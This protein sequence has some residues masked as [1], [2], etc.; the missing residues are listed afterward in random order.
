MVVAEFFCCLAAPFSEV[1]GAIAAALLT[2]TRILDTKAQQ[3]QLAVRRQGIPVQT[4]LSGVFTCGF[5]NVM[6]ALREVLP[7]VLR[8]RHDPCRASLSVQRSVNTQRTQVLRQ[9]RL[10]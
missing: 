4:L 3:R 2:P 10:I 9:I 5:L 1:A 8:N 6:R 7:H